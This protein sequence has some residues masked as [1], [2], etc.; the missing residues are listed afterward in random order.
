MP[1]FHVYMGIGARGLLLE[2]GYHDG[3]HIAFPGVYW[4]AMY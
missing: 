1:G 2:D 3:M 4:Y